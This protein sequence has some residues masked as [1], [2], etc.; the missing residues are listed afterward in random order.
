MGN[1]DETRT[2]GWYCD[3]CHR[4]VTKEHDHLTECIN[5]D[6]CGSNGLP[7][8]LCKTCGAAYRAD[9]ANMAEGETP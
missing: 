2:V 1:T 5:P 4:V 7:S 6:D 8:S 3:L 9:M